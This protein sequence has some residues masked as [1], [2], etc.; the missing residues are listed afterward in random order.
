V[1]PLSHSLIRSLTHLLIHLLLLTLLLTSLLNSLIDTQIDASD[2]IRLDSHVISDVA[3]LCVCVCVV[4][5]ICSFRG[6]QAVILREQPNSEWDYY[7]R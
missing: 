3:S 4:F 5:Q 1:H 7:W 6:G 2:L